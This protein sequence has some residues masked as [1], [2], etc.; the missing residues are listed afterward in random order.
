MSSQNGINNEDLGALYLQLYAYTDQLIKK[1]GWFRGG[2]TDSFLKGKQIHD[3]VSEAIEKY[4][5][6]PEK[7][8][9]ST[10]RS[11]EN[12]LKLHIIRTLVGND[13]KSPEN[14]TS[15]SFTSLVSRKD[16]ES[17]DG[18][19]YLDSILPFAEAYFDQEIDAK[20]VMGFI[21]LEVAKD[22]IVE[23]IYL[24]IKCYGWKRALVIKEFKMSDNDFDNGMRRLKT[25][26]NNTA[27]K[28]DIKKL[29]V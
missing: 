11:L 6:N 17:E 14:K 10:G 28:Y 27:K 19:S 4:L 23:E 20:E 15:K 2:R 3:Y 25:I 29:S 9:G 8:D 7:Y 12:Y 18:D 24:G 21:E 16:A 22:K 1:K 13:A 5:V 26:L